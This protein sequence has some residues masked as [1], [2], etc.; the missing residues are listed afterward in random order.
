M[1]TGSAI[2]VPR[3]TLTL[4]VASASVSTAGA[5]IISG[6]FVRA[7][8][9]NIGRHCR[10]LVTRVSVSK[11]KGRFESR[12]TGSARDGGTRCDVAA[13]DYESLLALDASMLGDRCPAGHH[14]AIR[15]CLLDGISYD[16][17]G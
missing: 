7:A 15:A 1:R 13:G 12:G 3:S 4:I 10:R 14:N 2:R 17:C 11:T 8:Y 16:R 5:R 6:L 9:S